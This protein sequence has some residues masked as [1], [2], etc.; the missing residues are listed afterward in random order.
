M[1]EYLCPY[2]EVEKV[3]D[4]NAKEM[5]C[6]VDKCPFDYMD[7]PSFD[8]FCCISKYPDSFKVS[9]KKKVKK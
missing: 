5:S 9:P 3:G 7:I 2:V 6:S 1:P 8:K 4:A